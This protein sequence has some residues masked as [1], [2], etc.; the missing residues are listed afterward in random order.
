[1]YENRGKMTGRIKGPVD[2]KMID[3]KSEA[4]MIKT[5]P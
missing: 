5:K 4:K 2:P 1:M 3:T